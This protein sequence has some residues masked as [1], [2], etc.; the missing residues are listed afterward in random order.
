MTMWFTAVVY[1]ENFH[2]PQEGDHSGYQRSGLN[3]K[4][5]RKREKSADKSR[6]VF[7]LCTQL[8]ASQ[9]Y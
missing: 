2:D 7:F 1:A 5:E 4:R 3:R 9:V 8:S 6:L